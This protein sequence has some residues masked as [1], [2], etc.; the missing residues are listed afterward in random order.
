MLTLM[1]LVVMKYYMMGRPEVDEG[2]ATVWLKTERSV[3]SFA[4]VLGEIAV[5]G[6]N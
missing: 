2:V 1:R 3:R 6:S 5:M 4:Y